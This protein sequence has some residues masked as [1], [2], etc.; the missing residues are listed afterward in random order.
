[1]ARIRQNAH[2][3]GHRCRRDCRSLVASFQLLAWALVGALSTGCA[4]DSRRCC[5]NASCASCQRDG[6]TNTAQPPARLVIDNAGSTAENTKLVQQA[7][8]QPAEIGRPA[9]GTPE[10]PP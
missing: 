4:A 8:Y 1:M 10:R 7:A 3:S 6:P 2:V 5:T 9:A